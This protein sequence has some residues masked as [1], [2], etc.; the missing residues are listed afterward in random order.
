MSIQSNPLMGITTQ[1]YSF[2]FHTEDPLITLV[3]VS[4]HAV[5]WD[6]PVDKVR[7]DYKDESDWKLF[8]RLSMNKSIAD[9]NMRNFAQMPE[10][11]SFETKIRKPR[12][13]TNR[14]ACCAKDK[15]LRAI[16]KILNNL[17]NNK[18]K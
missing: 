5:A 6:T 4:L 7:L 17:K 11:K 3:N 15:A 14:N 12:S 9:I 13:R 2:I 10:V 16:S 1:F 18:I 8:V